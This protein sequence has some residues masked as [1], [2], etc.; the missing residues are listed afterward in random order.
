[1]N[2]LLLDCNVQYFRDVVFLLPPGAEL[3]KRRARRRLS[4]WWKRCWRT[5]SSGWPTSRLLLRSG[6]RLKARLALVQHLAEKLTAHPPVPKVGGAPVMCRRRAEGGA[7]A[8]EQHGGDLQRQGVR[9]QQDGSPDAGRPPHRRAHA[10]LQLG[11]PGRP[12]GLWGHGQDLEQVRASRR[13]IRKCHAAARWPSGVWCFRSTLQVIRTMAC[14]YALCSMFVP[15]DRQ[16]I[17][18]TKV[19]GSA[20]TLVFDDAA[21]VGLTHLTWTR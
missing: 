3:R 10:G 11:Q 20:L 2:Q 14:E 15:G 13:Q 7:A 4:R 9:R 17:V 12:V 8:A 19:C 16:V 5:R 21:K 1:M 18:G 6:G